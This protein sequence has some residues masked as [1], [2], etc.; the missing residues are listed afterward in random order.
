MAYDKVALSHPRCFAVF[1]NAMAKAISAAEV[2]VKWAG[3]CFNVLL[4]A[5]DAVVVAENKDDMQEII[6]SQKSRFQFNVA[7]CKI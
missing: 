4:F 3:K 7:K 6:F 5:D 1:I 2:G